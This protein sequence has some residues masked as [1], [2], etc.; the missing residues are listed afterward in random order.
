M[1]FKSL[2]LTKL[3]S[4]T[5]LFFLLCRLLH[6]NELVELN[7]SLFHGLEN[8]KELWVIIRNRY[9]NLVHEIPSNI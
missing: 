1:K 5:Y 3:K 7:E 8:L 6:N 2:L 9:L 4:M